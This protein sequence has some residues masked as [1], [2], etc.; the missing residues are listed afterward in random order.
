[1]KYRIT[2][3]QEDYLC[4]RIFHIYHSK[5]GKRQIKNART[6]MI[7][8]SIFA[9][10]IVLMTGD[11]LDM[12]VI[13]TIIFGIASALYYFYAPKRIEKS[14]RKQVSETKADGK[15]PYHADAEIEF[16]ESMIVH[17]S[18]NGEFHVNYRD[19]ERIYIE[20]DYLYIYYNAVQAFAIPYRCLGE[21]KER[22][23]GYVI[24]K[25]S[26]SFQRYSFTA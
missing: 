4:F 25:R 6:R 24:D 9:I 21:D 7:K 2:L 19:T 22:V 16:L 14:I 1:M 11:P 26:E 12:I 13:Y 23:I 15:L 10:G 5:L 17:R 18:E 20:Q 3:D 8:V